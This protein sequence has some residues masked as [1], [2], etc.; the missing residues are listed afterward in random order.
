M[1]SKF[2]AARLSLIVLA[3]FSIPAFAREEAPVRNFAF[4]PLYNERTVNEGVGFGPDQ[5]LNLHSYSNPD[6]LLEFDGRSADFCRTV[7]QLE[8]YLRTNPKIANILITNS[9]SGK[10]AESSEVPL[11]GVQI[12]GDMADGEQTW[13]MVR[14]DPGASPGQS[15]PCARF[16]NMNMGS[17]PG[18]Q[19]APMGQAVP[20]RSPAR[21]DSLGKRDKTGDTQIVNAI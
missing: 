18:R 11:E 8:A 7:T 20:V 16:C 1:G 6:G 4:I 10:K 3:A 17:R 13:C 19:E 15:N 14:A 21:Y 12:W 5:G 9:N 2:Q